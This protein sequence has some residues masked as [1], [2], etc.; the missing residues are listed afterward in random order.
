[1]A[2][3]HRLQDIFMAEFRHG[4]TGNEILHNI[5][6]RAR[7]EGVPNPRVYSH[8]VGLFLHE[9]GPLIGLPWE[10]ERCVGRGDVR[11]EYNSCFTM[12]LS[13]TGQAPGWSN[14]EVRLPLEEDVVFTREGCRP[15]DGRQTAF[16]LI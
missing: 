2:Q 12:E 9:P 16:H 14:E 3:A 11:L 15:L 13:V 4:L 6:T 10:Q 7:R 1:L 8:S 5:L